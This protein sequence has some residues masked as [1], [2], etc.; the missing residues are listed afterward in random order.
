MALRP[1]PMAA[2]ESLLGAMSGQPPPDRLTHAVYLQTEGNPFFVADASRVTELEQY[3][4]AFLAP[5]TRV[6]VD[7][8]L[9]EA[10]AADAL[11]YVESSG[12]FSPDG[13]SFFD[14]FSWPSLNRLGDIAFFALMVMVLIPAIE[15]FA[16]QVRHATPFGAA[17]AL[18]DLR[19]QADQW[20]AAAIFSLELFASFSVAAVI[21]TLVSLF[22][23]SVNTAFLPG[24]S[25]LQAAGDVRGMLEV[26][27]RANV[28]VGALVCPLAAFAFV[29]ATGLVLL[30]SP[31]L[32]AWC[33]D[34]TCPSGVA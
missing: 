5:G 22:R 11:R 1:L 20:I 7:S 12:S 6:G 33:P 26:N 21:G 3:M 8:T 29:K 19:A 9:A 18:Y 10:G 23:K 28:M 24:L 15:A 32:L 25:K 2:V 27:S 17:G 14:Q 13:T 4:D 34:S 16:D 30:G 31:R